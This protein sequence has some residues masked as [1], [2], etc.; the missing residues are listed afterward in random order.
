MRFEKRIRILTFLMLT[1][2][3]ATY[4][5]LHNLTII[6]SGQEAA[7]IIVATEGT[8]INVS[9]QDEEG[10]E[11]Y[12]LILENNGGIREIRVL[13]KRSASISGNFLWNDDWDQVWSTTLEN[14]VIEERDKYV[15]I[16]TNSIYK[17]HPVS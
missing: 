4:S 13:A 15:K 9:A 14:P 3:L 8:R 16:V 7:S 17:K 12:S 1:L 11:V 10:G 2:L 6:V 5:S